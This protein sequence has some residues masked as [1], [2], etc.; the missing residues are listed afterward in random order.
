MEEKIKAIEFPGKEFKSKEDLFMTLKQH[1][2]RIITL[3]KAHIYKSFEKG[4][5]S[6]VD[7]SP[8]EGVI[9]AIDGA[10]DGFIY[11]II[12]TTR[13]IDSHKDCHFDG[14]FN[15]TL[16]NQQG[17]VVYALD[18]KL[19]FDSILA[20]EKDVVMSV[21]NI[22]W[23]LVGKDYEG[24]TQAL[25]FE[26]NKDSIRRKDVLKDIEDKASEFEN[27][28]RMVYHKILL[29]ID[30]NKKELQEEKSYFD[31]KINQ[32]ANKDI[33]LDDGYFWGV[34]ELGISKEGSL[35]V[36]GGSN[37]A[38]AI[39]QKDNGE[40]VL[41][42]SSQSFDS[43]SDTQNGNEPTKVTHKESIINFYKHLK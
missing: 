6:G 33:A 32:I 27:S 28:I 39:F 12:S 4:G 7:I 3:K 23:S 2:D 15:R 38:T 34:E 19:E 20:W 25:I 16:Q 18:H 37:D 31:S 29:G 10:R 22:D 30:S 11:P 5:V 13:Y 1:K 36:A 24:K 41:D 17:K 9:K 21:Q 14:C 42:T 26:I 40:P 8:S 43:S 35:V